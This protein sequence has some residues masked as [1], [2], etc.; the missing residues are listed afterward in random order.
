MLLFELSNDIVPVLLWV[1]ISFT[2]FAIHFANIILKDYVSYRRYH[3]NDKFHPLH[4]S[5]NYLDYIPS[6]LIKTNRIITRTV[7]RKEGPEDDLDDIYSSTKKIIMRNRGGKQWRTTQYSPLLK[8]IVL[9][10]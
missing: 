4:W 7:K 8:G 2:F 6:F 1:S 9:S 5:S 3:T 10:Y